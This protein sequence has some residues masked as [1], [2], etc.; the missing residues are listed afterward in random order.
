M[1]DQELCPHSGG[2]HSSH[3][4]STSAAHGALL[5]DKLSNNCLGLLGAKPVRRG[6]ASSFSASLEV[7]ESYTSVGRQQSLS[8]VS[9]NV[10]TVAER[11]FIYHRSVGEL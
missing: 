6:V 1:D 9:L 2:D 5:F 7:L 11:D 3:L 8:P 4:P 10:R